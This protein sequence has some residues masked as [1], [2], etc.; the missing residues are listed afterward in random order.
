ME[1][2]LSSAIIR[3]WRRQDE[4]AIVLHANDKEIWRNLTDRFP[5]PYSKRDAR[6]WIEF[7]LRSDPPMNFAIDIDGQA[8]GGIGVGIREDVRRKTAEIGYWIGKKYW[9]Q[10]IVTE[11]LK[12]FTEYAFKNY[13]VCRLEASVFEWNPASMRVLEKA[14][15]EREACLK[16][17]AF[18]DG[19]TIDLI[20]YASVR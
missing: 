1:L 17:A 9:G 18:K 8:V 20:I 2:R 13:D 19:K 16:K 14:G 10:G 5:F 11:A 4:D 7:N 12:V 6:D 3:E 15:Y